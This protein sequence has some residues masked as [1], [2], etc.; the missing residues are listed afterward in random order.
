MGLISKFTFKSYDVDNQDINMFKSIRYIIFKFYK[1]I[2]WLPKIYIL[3][4]ACRLLNSKKLCAPKKSWFKHFQF[5]TIDTNLADRVSWT[6]LMFFFPWQP[7]LLNPIFWGYKPLNLSTVYFMKMAS[8]NKR[9]WSDRA[10][11]IFTIAIKFQIARKFL[12]FS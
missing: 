11:G 12:R 6:N 2:F 4:L 1:I 9:K 8:L 7:F 5:D 3:P 10:E